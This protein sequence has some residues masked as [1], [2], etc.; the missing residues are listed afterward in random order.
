MAFL[1]K[2]EKTAL[3]VFFPKY[4]HFNNV[5]SKGVDSNFDSARFEPV[6]P[7]KIFLALRKLETLTFEA[8]L[9]KFVAYD[10][11]SGTGFLIRILFLFGFKRAIGIEYN[12]NLVERSELNLKKFITKGTCAIYCDDATIFKIPEGDSVIFF[13]NPFGQNSIE[14]FFQNNTDYFSSNK[15]YVVYINDLHV[16]KIPNN[17]LILFRNSL[18]KFSISV[19]QNFD[20]NKKVLD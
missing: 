6:S 3:A 16:D 8:E 5:P 20:N 17:F 12:Q 14:R 7:L 2:I 4:G 13:F 9:S 11:G 1:S 15:C 19:N 18:L 10:I